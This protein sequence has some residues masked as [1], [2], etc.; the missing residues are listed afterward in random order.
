MLP[1][2]FF[3]IYLRQYAPLLGERIMLLKIL[4]TAWPLFVIMMVFYIGG[5]EYI[6][7]IVYHLLRLI[8]AFL[9]SLSFIS[10]FVYIIDSKGRKISPLF[11][12]IGT[13]TLGIYILQNTLFA[14]VLPKIL[15]CDHSLFSQSMMP[16]IAVVVLVFCSL[17][18]IVLRYFELTKAFFFGK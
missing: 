10:L 17:G 14:N 6:P 7:F 1:S 5:K 2:F 8:V 11:L 16:L 9:G 18:V 15:H 4:K 12:R 3:G 13:Q